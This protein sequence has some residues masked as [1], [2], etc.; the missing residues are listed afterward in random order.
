MTFEPKIQI[1]QEIGKWG[2]QSGKKIIEAFSYEGDWSA[3]AQVELALY[4][5]DFENVTVARNQKI[6]PDGTEADLLM[7]IEGGKN[8]AIKL[9]C[10]ILPPGCGARGDAEVW[11]KINNAYQVMERV[12]TE[13]IRP[14]AMGIVVSDIAYDNAKFNLCDK[15]LFDLL[16]LY[17]PKTGPK[18]NLFFRWI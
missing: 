7:D 9:V 13:N 5:R 3:W 8:V 14:V 16:T 12:G 17:A 1:I 2:K 10:E 18:V 11:T 6:S 15:S 4:F